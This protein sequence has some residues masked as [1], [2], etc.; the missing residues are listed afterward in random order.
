MSTSTT[1]PS[2]PDDTASSTATLT[3]CRRRR[4]SRTAWTTDAAP[5]I[6][7]ATASIPTPSS[8]PPGSTE[9]SSEAA[10]VATASTA[11]GRYA[12]VHP[13][14]DHVRAVRAS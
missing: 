13:V 7:A 12:E 8:R 5:T 2:T 14:R 1:A 6:S 9:T 10:A 3:G 11:A 4:V